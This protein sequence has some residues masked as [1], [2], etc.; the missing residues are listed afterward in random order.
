MSS[1]VGA[2]TATIDTVL[3]AGNAILQETPDN[4]WWKHDTAG[5]VALAFPDWTPHSVYDPR[6]RDARRAGTRHALL[7]HRNDPHLWFLIYRQGNEL[8]TGRGSTMGQFFRFKREGAN[9]AYGTADQVITQVLRHRHPDADRSVWSLLDLFAGIYRTEHPSGHFTY[10]FDHAAHAP[11]WVLLTAADT[12]IREA[13]DAP[14]DTRQALALGFPHHTTISLGENT[15]RPNRSTALLRDSRHPDRWVMLSSYQPTLLTP[16]PG[17][18]NILFRS[19][20]NIAA[21]TRCRQGTG[22][23]LLDAARS[24]HEAF[25]TETTHVWLLRLFAEHHPDGGFRNDCA[26]E[27]NAHHTLHALND[28][29]PGDP[30]QVAYRAQPPLTTSASH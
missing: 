20:E 4:L 29:N 13:Q 12:H 23:D 5:V 15:M 3:A 6:H 30:V 16:E 21:T 7:R 8:L 17:H 24:T 11:E 18:P 2:V 9:Y 27:F 28:L 19:G 25:P 22:K 1:R 14:A 10:Q 26:A